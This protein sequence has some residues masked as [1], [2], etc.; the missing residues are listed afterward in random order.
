MLRRFCLSMIVLCLNMLIWDHVGY[1]QPIITLVVDPDVRTL[2]VGGDVQELSIIVR[3]DKQN[4]Q[5]EW[6][7]DGPGELAGDT[8]NPG[9]I[10]LP[11]QTIVEASTQVTVAV[12]V[13]DEQGQSAIGKVVFTLNAPQPTPTP[14]ATA[15]P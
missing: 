5:F 6:K 13:T 7:L 9:V 4:V 2:T 14:T 11:P 8:T 15:T 1:A 10:Y 12:T 3:T